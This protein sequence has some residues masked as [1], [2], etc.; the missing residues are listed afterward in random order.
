M[1]DTAA[2][3]FGT[4]HSDT[5]MH[6]A[7][8]DYIGGAAF[9]PDDDELPPPLEDESGDDANPYDDFLSAD[10]PD[11]EPDLRLI[12]G[13]K[14]PANAV[15]YERKVKG[16]FAIGVKLT[17]VNPKTV[18]DSAA[19]LMHGP[20]ISEKAGDLAAVDPR[21]ASIIDAITDQTENPKTALFMA[22]APLV[23]QIF[24]NHEPTIETRERGI[25]LPRGRRLRFRIPFKLGKRMRNITTEPSELTHKVL[26]NVSVVEALR[27]QGINIVTD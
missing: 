7:N 22:A 19:M 17:I 20:N 1:T 16:L 8:D 14:R 3:S 21:A 2:P 18:A 9:V 11:Y 25:K 23:L 6:D 4:D 27:K 13:K 12:T 15:K 26:T 10:E 5:A 24:R